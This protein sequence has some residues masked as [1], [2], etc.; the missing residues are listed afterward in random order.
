[1]TLA[2]V[3]AR[4]SDGHTL[5]SDLSLAF[6]RERTGVVGRNGAGKTTLL[7]LIAG[8]TEAGEGAVARLGRIGFLEQRQDPAPGASVAEALGV[9]AGL[10]VVARV[11]AGEGSGED[12]AEADWTLEARIAVALA[13]VDLAGVAL[14]RPLASLSGGEQ[15]RLRLAALLLD[16]PDLLV[17]DEP[18]NH[19]D[20]EG[21][22]IVAGVLERW[23]G[24][25]VVVSHDRS[26]LRRMDRIIELSSLGAATYGGNFDLYAERKAAERAAAE[27]DLEVAERETGR[28]ARESR[29]AL[30]QRARRDRAGRAFAAK[31]SEPK[32]LLGAMAERAE[33]SGAREHRLALRKAADAEAALT[34]ARERVERTRALVIPMPT[35][36]LATG[37][38]ILVLDEATWNAPD[39]RRIV[40]PVS[41]RLTGPERLAITGPNGAGKTTLLHLIAGRLAPATGR[42]ERPARAPLLDQET[43]LLRPDETLI[44]A[45]RRL[46]PEA[47]AQDAQAALARFLFRNTAARRVAGTLSGGERL[48]AG[49]ACVMTGARPPQLLILDEPTNHL[50]LHSIAAVEA[51]LTAYDGALVVVSHDADFLSA[52]GIERRIELR[53]G[54]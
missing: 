2:R 53:P 34:E 14:T 29:T 9:A 50:D 21:R 30:E 6:G 44:E 36:G 49:L 20:A 25:A 37:R 4:T 45:Y 10:A 43:A 33:N 47:T 39:G 42:V 18:T 1:V 54:G 46:N 24:G 27:R 13:E 41:L 40:G 31:K 28:V 52:I 17:L 8:R 12:L 7:R 5:F 35:T 32:I 11:L 22:V 19:L 3:A 38:T 26:L 15:T 48:R 51:A 23:Q 16:Q